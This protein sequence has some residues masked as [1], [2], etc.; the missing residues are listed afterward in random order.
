MRILLI[1]QYA[2]GPS[3]GMEFRPHWM[4][5]EWQKLGH[6]VLVVAGDHSHLRRT[7]P[8]L[9]TCQVDGVEFLTLRTP[10][11]MANGARR[12]ANILGFRAQLIRYIPR[13]TRWEPDVVIASSTHPMDI[14]PGLRIA[15][16]AGAV[17]VH[18]VHDLW[19]LTPRLLGGMS[20][21]HPMIMWM[22]REEDLACR[23]ADLVVSMLPATL[24][25]LRTRG[26]D[27][28]RWTYVSNGVPES[29]ILTD[30]SGPPDDSVFR[31]GYFG[32]HGPANDLETLIGAARLLK[33]EDIEIHLTGSGP[34][35]AQLQECARDLPKVHFHEA[36]PPDE[37]RVRMAQMDALFL[38][39]ALSPLYEHGIGMNKMFDYMA[40]GRPVIQAVDTP[41]SPAELAGCCV[42][43]TPGE[44]GAVATA[45]RDLC[46][47]PSYERFSMGTAGRS[48]VAGTATHSAL[49]ASLLGRA[50]AAKS[51][52]G[53][54]QR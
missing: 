28:E 3:L 8:P 23:R 50:Q 53:P 38:G 24:P 22:Q 44:P 49:A 30:D 32:A 18:E 36:V 45:I 5:I 9:G 51:S 41:T 26:L 52:S 4:A 20:D 40:A 46:G 43:C 14:R 29:A 2:G 39:A 15:R 19:P 37:A 17:F 33:D 47:R 1:N 48:Y 13:L 11:Y 16:A 7:Q 6:E 10:A 54:V 21:R 12:F 34:L 25:Y 27:P 42:R 31:V 35:K